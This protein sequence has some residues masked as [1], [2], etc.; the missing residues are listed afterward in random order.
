[1]P[2]VRLATISSSMRSPDLRHSVT[3]SEI[4]E[5]R[6]KMAVRF[7][8]A[9]SAAESTGGTCRSAMVLK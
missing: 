4:S 9:L 7:S 1:M 5:A 3:V 8:F 6:S 2:D